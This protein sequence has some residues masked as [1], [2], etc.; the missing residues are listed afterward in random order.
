[1]RP[2]MIHVIFMTDHIYKSSLDDSI[3]FSQLILEL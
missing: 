3:W 2:G 1:M